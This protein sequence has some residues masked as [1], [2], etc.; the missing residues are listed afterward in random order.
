[1]LHRV[2]VHVVQACQIRFLVG[3]PC[4]AEIEPHLA[5]WRTVELVDPTSS[6]YVQHTEHVREVGGVSRVSRRMSNEVV[7]VGKHGPRFELP[8]EVWR[9]GEQPAMQNPQTVSA[10]KMMS[11]EV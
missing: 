6:L 2:L 8:A 11:F 9:H 5:G 3:Q 7:M 1:M 4:L 10:S